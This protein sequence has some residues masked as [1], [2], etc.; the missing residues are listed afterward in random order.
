MNAR[1]TIGLDPAATFERERPHLLSLAFRILGSQADTEDVVQEA[2]IRFDAADTRDI[3]NVPAWLTTVTTRLCLDSL[4]RRRESPHEP[5]ESSMEL[6]ERHDGPE[7]LALLASELTEAFTIV[8]DQ[9][10][11][12][13]RV[14]L[15][16]HDAFG[17]PF[18]E[19]ARIL[20]TT[21][22]SARKLAS[23]GRHRVRQRT[24]ATGE[25]AERV[26]HVVEA[27]LH[28]AQEGDTDRLVALLD[29][30]VVRTADA[31]AVPGGGM[32]R[33]QGV[34]AVIAETRALQANAQRARVASI[35]GQPGIVV[36]AN[37]GVQAA[38]VFHIAGDRIVQYDVIA[39]PWRLMSLSI[40]R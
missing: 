31:Q 39:D 23:R 20:G 24:N 9:L 29:P 6:E 26:R 32:Q 17:L 14:A 18:D 27:F 1:D 4:R 16:L 13:Q 28:A 10:T 11:P 15:V 7:E 37:R 8:L 25:R 40:H 33:L 19:I 22:G 36:L 2:W 5:A 35:D 21:I 3:R 34:R 38:L 30:S 12:P